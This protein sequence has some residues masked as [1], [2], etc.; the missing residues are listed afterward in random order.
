MATV[1]QP[2]LQLPVEATQQIKLHCAIF[3]VIEPLET[4]TVRLGKVNL[5]IKF[6]SGAISCDGCKGFFRRSIRKEHNYKCRF[7]Q[8]CNVDKSEFY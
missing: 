6:F 7:Q 8:N 4:T 2:P 3:A 1:L 5:I